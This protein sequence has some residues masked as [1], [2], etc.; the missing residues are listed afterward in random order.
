[1]FFGLG[2]CYSN[3]L[4]PTV[5]LGR[6][7]SCHRVHPDRTGTAGDRGSDPNPEMWECYISP[8]A[9]S[10]QEVPSTNILASPVPRVYMGLELQETWV[11]VPW[12]PTGSLTIEFQTWVHCCQWVFSGQLDSEQALLLMGRDP[13]PCAL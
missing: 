3:T 9:D 11:G 5:H 12:W 8:T 13:P 7:Q 10:L 2:R 4:S 6:F 1:M